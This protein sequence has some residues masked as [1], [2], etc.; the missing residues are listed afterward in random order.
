M[1]ALL[2][3]CVPPAK[4]AAQAAERII[5]IGTAPVAGTY[6]PVG[7]ALCAMVNRDR[8]R[9]G[10]RC[11]VEPTEGSRDN[12]ERLERGELDFA[13]V[14]SDWQYLAARGGYREDGKP[15]ADLRA[16][17]SLHAQPISLV[18][19]PDS[20]I[21]A[22]EDLKGRRV[23]L[24]PPGS[25]TRAA[26]ETLIGA[27]GFAPG[28]FEAIDESG[29]AGQG[30]ALCAAQIDAFVVPLNHPNGVLA[31]AA[32]TCGALL[33][34]IAGPQVDRLIA[35]WPFYGKAT[36]PAGLYAGNGEPVRSFGVRTTLVTTADRPSDVVYEMVKAA[37]DNLDD[38]TRQFGALTGLRR[39]EMATHG[40]S[41]DLHDGALRYYQDAGLR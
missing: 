7:G 15:F 17:L 24:G 32:A 5:V 19:H 23:G 39:E 14:Q 28:D 29:L 4:A 41:A 1:L 13:L 40:I 16:V 36:I 6:Y 2:A 37:L 8:A 22:V 3:A 34:D 9:H 10:L 38:L 11:L 26:A 31:A 35:D 18:A 27:F 21:G 25:G 12:L 30:A 20:Q 33:V